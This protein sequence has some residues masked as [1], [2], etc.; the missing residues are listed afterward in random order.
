MHRTSTSKVLCKPAGMPRRHCSIAVDH[1]S[2]VVPARSIKS[3]AKAE[4]R[5]SGTVADVPCD[6][7]VC[8][9]LVVKKSALRGAILDFLPHSVRLEFGSCAQRSIFPSFPFSFPSLSL[10][11]T[12]SRKKPRTVHR[13][14]ALSTACNMSQSVL[15]SRE[16]SLV[17]DRSSHVCSVSSSQC[18]EQPM[19]LSR[20]IS[21]YRQLL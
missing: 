20:D 6:K 16:I 14:K 18:D 12:V 11:T 8:E 13:E 21:L 17:S 19:C 10:G 3:L 7:C 15:V 9:L 5:M 4:P 1:G 2:N